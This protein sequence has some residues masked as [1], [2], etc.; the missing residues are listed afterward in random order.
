MITS[1]IA[2][3]ELIGII[4]LAVYALLDNERIYASVCAAIMGSIL[5]G[6]LGYQLLFGMVRTENMD[7]IQDNGLGYYCIMIAVIMFV[8]ALA[9]VADTRIKAREARDV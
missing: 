8:I 6:V 2:G 7:V 4:I 1:F 3:L 9:V 5:S